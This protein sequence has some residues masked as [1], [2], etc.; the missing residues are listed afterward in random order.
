M[1]PKPHWHAESRT[2]K[3]SRNE[4]SVLLAVL[5]D[6]GSPDDAAAAYQTGIA[7]AFPGEQHAYAPPPRGVLELDPAWHV[8]R[9]LNPEG[10]E[11]LLRAAVATIGHDKTLMVTELELLRTVCALLQCPMPAL[12]S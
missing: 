2:L 3:R 11:Q 5:A 4:V 7:V 10:K 1:H 9:E 8:L 6:A 12:T